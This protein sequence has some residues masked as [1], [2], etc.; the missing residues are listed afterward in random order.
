M[1]LNSVYI[2]YHCLSYPMQWN[3]VLPDIIRLQ[4]YLIENLRGK[5][6][7]AAIGKWNRSKVV[8]IARKISRTDTDLNQSIF[9]CPGPEQ[10]KVLRSRSP[11]LPKNRSSLVNTTYLLAIM[12]FKLISPFNSWR[13]PQATNPWDLTLIW[14]QAALLRRFQNLQKHIYVIKNLEA[15]TLNDRA[16]VLDMMVQSIWDLAQLEEWVA[17]FRLKVASFL[18]L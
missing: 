13:H 2:Y 9:A 1:F 14:K 12:I 4:V 5:I 18:Y 6:G 3:D 15:E 16:V 17:W 8:L 7:I 11:R 10:I